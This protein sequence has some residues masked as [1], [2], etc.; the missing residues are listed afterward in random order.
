MQN[1]SSPADVEK[2]M[3]SCLMLGENKAHYLLK[4]I[5]NFSVLVATEMDDALVKRLRVE[6]AL[7]QQAALDDGIKARHGSKIYATPYGG[8][9]LPVMS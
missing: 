9:T 5:S 1:Y 4:A 8:N 6:R 7:D 2:V 3:E